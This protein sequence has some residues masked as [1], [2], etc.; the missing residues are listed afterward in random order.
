MNNEN[1]SFDVVDT[2]PSDG[3]GSVAP[4]ADTPMDTP[5]PLEVVSVDEL[6]DRLTASNTDETDGETDTQEEQAEEIEPSLSDQYFAAALENDSDRE[7]VELLTEIKQ[8]V[9]RH[10]ALTTNFED[11]TVSEGLLL[12]LFLSVFGSWLVRLLKGGFSW[13]F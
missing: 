13:L 12:L 1:T 4:V 9:Q 7:V 11:Y 5:A 6:I 8:E 3:G 2:V 10:P